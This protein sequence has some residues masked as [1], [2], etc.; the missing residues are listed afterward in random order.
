GPFY[1]RLFRWVVHPAVSRFVCNSAFVLNALLAHGIPQAKTT[2]IYNTLAAD[3]RAAADGQLHEPD[4]IIY[5]GQVIPEQNVHL[6]LDAVQELRQRGFQV[7]LEIV[8]PMTGWEAPQYEGY[9][10]RLLAQAGDPDLAGCVQ[11]VGQRDDVSKRMASAAVHVCPSEMPEGCPNVVLEAK[12]AGVPTVAFTL[13]PFP[14]LIKHG[15]NGWLCPQASSSSLA[16]G[17]AALI[18]DPDLRR[19]AGE[20]ARE[21]LREFSRERFAAQWWSTIAGNAALP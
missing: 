12:Q 18:S 5:V 13:G 2:V 9:R 3:R 4:K 16:E 6:L 21:S 20:R 10:E 15:E 14:E 7:R 11:F 17:I 19:R 8:G 1:R